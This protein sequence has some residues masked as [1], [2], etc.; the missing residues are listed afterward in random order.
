MPRV[1]APLNVAQVSEI[2]EVVSAGTFKRSIY[3]GTC[4]GTSC[5]NV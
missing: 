5:R 4:R 1:A 3:W 2:I